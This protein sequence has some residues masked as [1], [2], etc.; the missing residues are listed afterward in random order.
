[1]NYCKSGEKVVIKYKFPEK[2]EATYTS[3]N[4]PASITVRPITAKNY[5]FTGYYAEYWVDD[6]DPSTGRLNR[7]VKIE[8]PSSMN[9]I[10]LWVS[11]RLIY[12]PFEYPLMQWEGPTGFS[13]ESGEGQVNYCQ[14]QWFSIAINYSNAEGIRE[15]GYFN[16]IGSRASASRQSSQCFISRVVRDITFKRFDNKQDPLKW[17]IN[18]VDNKGISFTDHGIGEP[19]FTCE[20]GDCPPNSMRCDSSRYPGYDC[21]PCSSLKSEIAAIRSLARKING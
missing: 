20:C 5:V 21:V 18:I 8:Y 11:P 14:Q 4:S 1:M 2:A 9:Y 13:F 19:T 3:Q 12:P 15:T 6:Y 17:E 7:S 16:L 10:A